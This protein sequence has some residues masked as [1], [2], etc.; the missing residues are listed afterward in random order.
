MKQP[1]EPVN[2]LERALVAALQN[3]LP[4]AA[5]VQTL[6]RSTVYILSD[7]ALP[8]GGLWGQGAT[9]MVLADANK[10]PFLAIFT[11][12]E[13]SAAWTQRQTTFGCGLSTDF[14]GLLQGM[15]PDQGLV[16]NPGLAAGF[17]LQP[18]TV[19]QLRAQAL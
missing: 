19:A 5:F 10:T 18:A 1:F 8:S 3:Q 6:R 14:A 2:E 17:E 9:P 4:V 7:K 12:P 13:R 16:I 11:A 15:A